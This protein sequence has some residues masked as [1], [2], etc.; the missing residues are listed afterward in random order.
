M[1]AITCLMSVCFEAYYDNK[2]GKKLFAS[3]G[4][5]HSYWMARAFYLSYVTATYQSIGVVNLAFKTA[6]IGFK[7][8]YMYVLLF[9]AAIA[10]CGLLGSRYKIR[11]M[12]K[13]AFIS[14]KNLIRLCRIAAIIAYIALRLSGA[15]GTS[16]IATLGHA[17]GLHFN[18]WTRPNAME[19]SLYTPLEGLPEQ[20]KLKAI[21]AIVSANM[22][23]R[24]I[25]N[26]LS[27]TDGDMI[28]KTHHEQIFLL[29]QTAYDS[30]ATNPIYHPHLSDKGNPTDGL[31]NLHSQDPAAL[32][33][34]S[35]L[36]QFLELT[37]PSYNLVGTTINKPL[38]IDNDKGITRFM[39]IIQLKTLIQQFLS[40]EERKLLKTA[41][42]SGKRDTLSKQAPLLPIVFDASCNLAQEII[43]GPLFGNNQGTNPFMHG[44]RSKTPE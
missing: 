5:A 27:Y 44:Y 10:G 20:D 1:Q 38:F 29:T 2:Q 21:N 25:L 31:E 36:V 33:P 8:P 6:K 17:M 32:V 4:S 40:D 26:N 3:P 30:L 9:G 7:L 43:Q 35:R 22:I 13:I 18:R 39:K 15:H 37:D 34:L 24:S 19:M 14:Q 16:L 23:S 11:K 28:T 42:I 12:E 41:L